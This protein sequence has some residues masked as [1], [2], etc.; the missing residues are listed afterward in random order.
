MVAVLSNVAFKF[1][2]DGA[3]K[4]MMN[5]HNVLKQNAVIWWEIIN[6]YW[7]TWRNKN[8]E[9]AERRREG[10][11]MRAEQHYWWMH[12]LMTVD[13]SCHEKCLQLFVRPRCLANE[14]GS[15]MRQAKGGARRV[16]VMRADHV[17]KEP[18][19]LAGQ[20]GCTVTRRHFWWQDPSSVTYWCKRRHQLRA[21]VPWLAATPRGV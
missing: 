3:K 14:P 9:T 4:T 17:A 11:L 1:K 2:P 18:C 16:R 7:S 13:G 12:S 8:Y 6:M 21:T 5:T 19:S 20:P 10:K 15:W